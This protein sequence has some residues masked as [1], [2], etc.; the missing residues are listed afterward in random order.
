MFSPSGSRTVQTGKT[1]QTQKFTI[2]SPFYL[3]KTTTYVPTMVKAKKGDL[4]SV[5]L[6]A[7]GKGMRMGGT[8]P[9]QFLPLGDKPIICHSLEIFLKIGVVAE[10]VVV[11]APSYRHLLSGYS[12]TFADPG[13]RRQD[14]VFNGLCQLRAS[15]SWVCVHDGARPLITP[16]MVERLFQEGRR[17]GAACVGMPMIPTVKSR[18]ADYFVD[19]TLDRDSLWEIQTPQFLSR[20]LMAQGFVVTQEKGLTLTDDVSLAELQGHPVKLVEGAHTN[21]KI[22]TPEDLIRARQLL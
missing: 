8:I 15:A 17:H 14:S 5:I 3:L 21:L 11:C 22:T 10:I 1:C 16:E 19:K 20:K 7:G 12:V 13:P 9:K 2:Y 4:V 18:T 6:L